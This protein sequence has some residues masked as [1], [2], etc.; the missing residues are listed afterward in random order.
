[1][2]TG[3]LRFSRESVTEEH[4]L[5]GGERAK[6]ESSNIEDQMASSSSYSSFCYI[7]WV[8]AAA[9]VGSL[10]FGGS[11]WGFG[12]L[13][14]SVILITSI[15]LILSTVLIFTLFREQ[16]VPQK[17]VTEEEVL[18]IKSND[19]HQEIIEDVVVPTS[20]LLLQQQQHKEDQQLQKCLETDQALLLHDYSSS[21][22]LLSESES[23][24]D[25]LS[26]SEDSEV[27]WPFRDIVYQ[28]LDC[29]DDGSISDEESLIEIALPSGHYVDHDQDK[30][31]H[32]QHKV[33]VGADHHFL[34]RESILKQHSLMELLAELNDMNEED[35]LIEIDISMGSIK[36]SR[37]EIEA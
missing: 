31:N 2:N 3:V 10:T 17:S 18:I 7:K 5:I 32:I 4:R 16:K 33:V 30:L 25:H 6:L 19:D 34:P 12:L 23:I 28:S 15:V 27:D 22:D 37:F 14:S 9:V 11:I 1:M 35:N 36:C 26:I 24:D 29:S 8:A 21:P 20:T 13:S